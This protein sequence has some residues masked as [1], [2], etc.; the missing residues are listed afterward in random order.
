MGLKEKT[1]Q[2]ITSGTRKLVESKYIK[3]AVFSYDMAFNS[4]KRARWLRQQ[5]EVDSK[6][7]RVDCETQEKNSLSSIKS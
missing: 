5:L 7:G 3:K 6:N 1:L 4:S 2:V